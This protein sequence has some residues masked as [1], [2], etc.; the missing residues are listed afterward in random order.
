[1]GDS[2]KPLLGD[3]VHSRAY[4]YQDENLTSIESDG[5]GK[6]ERMGKHVQE[7]CRH[8]PSLRVIKVLVKNRIPKLAD[9]G[10]ASP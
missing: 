6:V 3:Q 8:V 2:R 7:N 4:L 10:F 1:M 5:K 9:S